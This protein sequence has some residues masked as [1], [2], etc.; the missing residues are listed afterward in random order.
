MITKSDLDRLSKDFA[1]LIGTKISWLSLPVESLHGFEPS[2]IAVIVNTL[3]DAAMP[4]IQLLAVDA[5]NAKKLNQLG[6]TKAPGQIGERESYPDYVHVSGKRVELKGLFI[7]SPELDLKRPPTQREPSA[8]LK[9]NVTIDQINP[10]KDILLVAAVQIHIID[11]NCYPVIVDI[12][13][14]PMVDVIN[15]RDRRLADAG[16]KWFGGTPKVVNNAGRR[17][18]K[19]GS[20]YADLTNDDFERD[21]NFGKLKRIPYEPLQAFMRK[22]GVI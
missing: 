7:D 16:G 9:E 22:H 10:D 2:Q 18:L 14:F 3:L 15:A 8:R 20:T 5:D 11:G 21:T 6:I 4:Q 19:G 12:G 1:C 13:L 17:K